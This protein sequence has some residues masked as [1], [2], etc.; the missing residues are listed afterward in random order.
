MQ[1]APDM[2]WPL[3]T[4]NMITHPGLCCAHARCELIRGLLQLRVGEQTLGAVRMPVMRCSPQRLAQG[5]ELQLLLVLQK[6]SLQSRG[7]PPCCSTGCREA[8]AACFWV[9]GSSSQWS[10]NSSQKQG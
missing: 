2:L 4:I 8:P 9:E 5:V 1:P 6:P 10:T 3:P 7:R